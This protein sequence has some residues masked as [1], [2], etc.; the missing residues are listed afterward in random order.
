MWI[1]RFSRKGFRDPPAPE[2]RNPKRQNKTTPGS[3][4]TLRKTQKTHVQ[5]PCCLPVIS[6][7]FPPPFRGPSKRAISVLFT[8]H[9]R[10]LSAT[11]PARSVWLGAAKR[12]LFGNVMKMS[13]KWPENGM[14]VFCT[15]YI[16]T[17]SM[18]VSYPT[19]SERSW[20]CHENVMKMACLC[21]VPSTYAQQVWGWII[22]PVRK[23]HENGMKMSWKWPENGM[24]V[25]CT[26]HIRT[27]SMGVNVHTCSERS[28]KCH[29]NVMKM[30]W[31]WHVCLLYLV[32][33]HSKYGGELSHLFR[34]V[35]KMSWKCHENVMKIACL[36]FAPCT[37]AQL[38]WERVIPHVRKGHENLLKMAWKWYVCVLYLSHV[39][40]KYGG[41]LSHMFGKATQMQMS[42]K[43]HWKW[44]VCVLYLVHMHSIFH[45]AGILHPHTCC[46]HVPDTEPKH[47]MFNPFSCNFHNLS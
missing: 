28:W 46:A 20:R 8:G 31:K 32:H 24:F 21:F 39:H 23:C 5:F 15:L 6:A 14:F 9:F 2:S 34:K 16:C 27:A 41:E 44:H 26:L 12:S 37:Y 33:M 47:A 45:P 43:R 13:W 1:M 30:A 40:S 18:G 10:Y 4:S 22:T 11:C 35:M 42:W 38:V 25:F 7:A 17:A 19:C 29:E 3:K 36:C